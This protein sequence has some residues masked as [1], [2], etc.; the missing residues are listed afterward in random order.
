MA[1]ARQG[2][3]NPF[4]PRKRLLVD[5]ALEAVRRSGAD[6]W[7]ARV[8]SLD[9]VSIQ[10]TLEAPQGRMSEV[11]STFMEQ[12]VLFMEQVVLE[13]QRRLCHGDA[14]ED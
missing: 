6:L 7:V 10:E 2:R 4:S 1:F 12:V 9:G 8:A 13:N 11:G 3:A 5:L 14:A